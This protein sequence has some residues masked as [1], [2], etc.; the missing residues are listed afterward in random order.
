[1]IIKI[2]IYEIYGCGLDNLHLSYGQ[3]LMINIYIMY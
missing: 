1:M 3:I 2:G